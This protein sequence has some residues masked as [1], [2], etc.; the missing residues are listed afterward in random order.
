MPPHAVYLWTLPMFH[1]NGWCFPWTMAANA[2]VNVCLRRVDAKVIFDAIREHE[3]THMCGAPIVYGM[4]INATRTTCGRIDHK[5]DAA[6]AGAAPPAAIIEGAEQ[7]G[8]DITHVY[9][10]TETYGPASVCAKQE[11]WDVAAA[12]ASAPD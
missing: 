9:G 5:V 3:V 7:I 12:G 6:D 8:F 4:L 1:C 2:G 10:L 11:E